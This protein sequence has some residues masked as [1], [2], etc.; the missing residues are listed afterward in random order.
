MEA[1]VVATALAER[2]Q[3]R[4]VTAANA[5]LAERELTEQLESV[6][7][8]NRVLLQGLRSIEP[9]RGEEPPPGLRAVRLEVRGES[10]MEGVLSFLREVETSPLLLK[11]A[12]MSLQPEMARPPATRGRGRNEDR[13]PPRPTGVVEFVM[14]IEAYAQVENEGGLP[15]DNGTEGVDR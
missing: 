8:A 12:G 1:L 3:F 13:G 4:L 5:A 9:A 2:A 11:V 14:I 10:D 6:A 15:G 7:F